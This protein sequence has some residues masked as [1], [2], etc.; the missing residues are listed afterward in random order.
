MSGAD[1]NL[2]LGAALCVGD[3]A[4]ADPFTDPIGGLTSIE[5]AGR[6][7]VLLR[8]LGGGA[9]VSIARVALTSARTA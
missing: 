8:P 5:R 4:G 9:A 7:R 6:V 2:H 3:G 1:G